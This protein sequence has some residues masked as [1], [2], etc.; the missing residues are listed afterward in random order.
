LLPDGGK[1]HRSVAGR[2]LIKER[3]PI[4]RAEIV[5]QAL[6]LILQSGDGLQDLQS[7]SDVTRSGR[8]D[9]VGSGSLRGPA[10]DGSIDQFRHF[11]FQLGHVVPHVTK[12]SEPVKLLKWEMLKI[13]DY[14]FALARKTFLE[15]AL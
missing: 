1:Y 12:L 11:A 13:V 6:K 10:C 5:V 14:F 7:E 15:S 3:M 4:H 9:Q 8:P 2:A